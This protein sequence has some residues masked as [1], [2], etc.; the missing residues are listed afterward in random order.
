MQH[1]EEWLR[2]IWFNRTR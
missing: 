2:F 1:Y